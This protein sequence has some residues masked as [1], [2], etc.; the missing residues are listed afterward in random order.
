MSKITISREDLYLQVWEIPMS[1]LAIQYGITSS[2]LAKIC[3]RL[4]VPH[5]P[6]GHWAKKAAGK[7]ILTYQLSEPGEGT[8]LEVSIRATS[9]DPEGQSETRENVE[10]D[11]H[12]KREPIIKSFIETER[13]WKF[14]GNIGWK[15][16]PRH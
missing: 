10:F 12:E 1:R 13:W 15:K 4:K 2:G 6:R 3:G 14:K 9:S 5:P 16:E 7:K 8:P 11:L